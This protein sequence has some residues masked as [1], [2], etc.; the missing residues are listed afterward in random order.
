MVP[1]TS[2]EYGLIHHNLRIHFGIRHDVLHN[3]LIHDDVLVTFLTFPT[4]LAFPKIPLGGV[5]MC[6]DLNQFIPFTAPEISGIFFSIPI[7]HFFD[8]TTFWATSFASFGDTFQGRRVKYLFFECLTFSKGH[9][10]TKR[11]QK[12]NA[13]CSNANECVTHDLPSG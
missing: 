8:A 2:S 7:Q 9:F 12:L 5:E 1:S 6:H 13:S 4:F 11:T 10:H 3:F